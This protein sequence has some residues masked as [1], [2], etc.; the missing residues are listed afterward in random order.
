MQESCEKKIILFILINIGCKVCE[1]R[2]C[3]IYCLE[4]GSGTAM[5]R[6]AIGYG[7]GL[8]AAESQELKFFHFYSHNIIGFVFMLNQ[9]L[10]FL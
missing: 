8:G 9:Q 2:I 4:D 7:E 6:F 3:A 5:V 10:S 1:K